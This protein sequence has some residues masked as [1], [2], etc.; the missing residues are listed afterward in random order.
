MVSLRIEILN[1]A[2]IVVP[3]DKIAFVVSFVFVSKGVPATQ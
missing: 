2:V 3:F 1:V